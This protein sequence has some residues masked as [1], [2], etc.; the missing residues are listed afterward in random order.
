MSLITWSDRYSV[1]VN[2]MDAEHKQLV[3]YINA[4][5]DAMRAGSGSKELGNI[6][7]KL[8][9]YTQSHFVSE[10]ALMKKVGYPELVQHQEAHEELVSQVGKIKEDMLSGKMMVSVKTLNFLRDWLQNHIMKVDRKYGDWI[11]ANGG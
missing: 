3:D 6:L 1:L 10:E 4:L 2:E 9:K 8:V 5:N 11:K 7:E